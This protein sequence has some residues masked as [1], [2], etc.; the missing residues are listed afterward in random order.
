MR[1][2]I[3]LTCTLVVCAAAPAAADGVRSGKNNVV[4]ASPTV[5]GTAIHRAR[6]S[7]FRTRADTVD[8]SNLAEANPHDCTGCEGIAAAFQAVIVLGKPSV[9]TPNNWAVA[10]NSNCTRCGAFAYAYQYVVQT[11]GSGRLSWRARA[12]V[13]NIEQRA[14]ELVDAGLPY[15]ELDARL[16]ELAAKFQNLIRTDLDRTGQ[17]PHGG[18]DDDEQ[19]FLAPAPGE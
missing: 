13:E 18:R 2:L 11:E 15:P 5:D 7:V 19:D 12:A 16:Q 1:R 4:R 14:D 3:A 6:V 10:V 9:F 8:S 17:D